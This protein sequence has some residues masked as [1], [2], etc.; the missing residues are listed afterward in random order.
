MVTKFADIHVE[1]WIKVILIPDIYLPLK[2][3]LIY[4]C[5]VL[6]HEFKPLAFDIRKSKY[7]ISVMPTFALIRKRLVCFAAGIPQIRVFDLDTINPPDLYCLIYR[8]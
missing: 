2:D 7:S 8:F 6:D 5:N 4:P 1:K 3:P